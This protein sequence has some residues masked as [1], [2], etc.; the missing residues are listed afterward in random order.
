ML[1]EKLGHPSIFEGPLEQ[2]K[3]NEDSPFSS[4][5]VCQ[6]E[7]KFRI[8]VNTQITLQVFENKNIFPRKFSQ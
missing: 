3:T 7:D 2:R 6:L 4:R 5:H 8:Y 1:Q